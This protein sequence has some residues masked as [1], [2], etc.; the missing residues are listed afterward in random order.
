MKVPAAK[1][2]FPKWLRCR[3]KMPSRRNS[4]PHNPL[5]FGNTRLFADV[6]FMRAEPRA[7]GR[8]GH[9]P[10]RRGKS[11]CFIQ[12]PFPAL[13]GLGNRPGC[14]I[15]G[16]FSSPADGRRGLASKR[17]GVLF[18]LSGSPVPRFS[19]SGGAGMALV[20]GNAAFPRHPQKE[21]KGPPGKRRPHN[22]A[23]ACKRLRA[24]AL[25]LAAAGAARGVEQALFFGLGQQADH[26]DEEDERQQRGHVQM[27]RL[28]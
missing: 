18:R 10:A 16:A 5:P 13:E 26:G 1:P 20:A 28:L 2:P 21:Q 11:L 8:S 17:G 7:R 24:R 15:R 19:G 22:A 23:S 25:F 9:T 6:M 4:S 12:T 14:P 27:P 3:G